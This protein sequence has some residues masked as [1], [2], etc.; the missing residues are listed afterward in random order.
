MKI[1]ISVATFL[2]V[3]CPSRLK[4]LAREYN[5]YLNSPE[6]IEAKQKKNRD[7]PHHESSIDRIRR[8]LWLSLLLVV[9]AI[10]CA[11]FIGYFYVQVC[12]PATPVTLE[13]L[14]YLGIGI[15]LWSTLAKQGWGI[16]TMD[17]TTV[18]ERVDEFLYRGFY[19]F[20]SFLLALSVAL[21]LS[22]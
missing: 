19:V 22:V 15:L 18:P 5:E 11:A 4:E 14:Q 6:A 16:Q 1:N 9:A 3:F 10:G 8:G 20:G 12:G 21:Q 2:L 7:E 17:G 13:F